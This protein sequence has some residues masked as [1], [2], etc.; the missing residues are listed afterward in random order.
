MHSELMRHATAGVE[1]GGPVYGT[2]GDT[3]LA[4][5]RAEAWPDDTTQRSRGQLTYRGGDQITDPD[6]CGTWHSHHRR[7]AQ[8]SPEDLIGAAELLD[9]LER[10]SLVL[11]I[12]SYGHGG[13]SGLARGRFDLGAWLVQRD[14][15][16]QTTYETTRRA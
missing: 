13:E 10:S 7:D 4:I 8:P 1:S 6:F 5:D 3:A 2:I 16:G 11:I 9:D 12:A 14:P 15:H